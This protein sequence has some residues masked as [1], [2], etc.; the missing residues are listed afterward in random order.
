MKKYGY[1]VMMTAPCGG[2]QAVAFQDERFL[3]FW[4]SGK[5]AR[6]ELSSQN[7]HKCG[8]TAYHKAAD[9]SATDVTRVEPNGDT[10]DVFPGYKED[11]PQ[12]EFG[13]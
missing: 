9:Y 3:D 12:L 1:R 10:R 6:K 8:G 5:R 4:Q 2:K 7:C 11:T 13:I